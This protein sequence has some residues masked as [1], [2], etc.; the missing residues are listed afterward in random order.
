[1]ND[2]QIHT[3]AVLSSFCLRVSAAGARADATPTYATPLRLFGL[4][5]SVVG[6]RAPVQ[7][8]TSGNGIQPG[9]P[10]VLGRGSTPFFPGLVRRN[11]EGVP[12]GGAKARCSSNGPPRGCCCSL[13]DAPR[14]YTEPPILLGDVSLL[15]QASRRNDPN[16]PN[17]RARRRRGGCPHPPKTPTRRHDPFQHKPSK[18]MRYE[19]KRTRRC[20]ETTLVRPP[21]PEH[22]RRTGRLPDGRSTHG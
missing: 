14:Q 21:A 3:T 1:M 6:H 2:H 20:G 17:G 16:T 15:R 11:V 12:F 8:H 9:A 7:G 10:L 5:V 4:G 22:R 19:E 13:R 18:N